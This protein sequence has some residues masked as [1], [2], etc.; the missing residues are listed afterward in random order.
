MG[1]RRRIHAL[2][3]AGL[4]GAV[5]S[6]TAGQAAQANYAGLF[7]NIPTA[8]GYLHW[9]S[10]DTGK[11]LDV[12]GQSTQAG[13]AVVEMFCRV[14]TSQEWQPAVYDIRDHRTGSC[15]CEK[16]VVE[17]SNHNSGYCLAVADLS[18]ANSTPIVQLPC[19]AG[20]QREYWEIDN[21]NIPYHYSD[22]QQTPSMFVNRADFANGARKCIDV[23]VIVDQ[24]PAQAWDC[25]ANAFHQAW[26][27]F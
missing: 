26:Y 6:V 7:P 19:A 22:Y 20:D 8:P 2:V 5:V 25:D 27:L 10:A 15:M 9:F 3:L 21:S 18:G 14:A 24:G 13:A 1:N 12:A 16:V 4:L 11:C 23:R 17:Y